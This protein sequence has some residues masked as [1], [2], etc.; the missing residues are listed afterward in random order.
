MSFL[1]CFF[2]SAD[3]DPQQALIEYSSADGCFVLQDLNSSHG[4]LVNNCRVHNAAVRL[5]AGDVVGFGFDGRLFK[6]LTDQP[7]Q[8]ICFS[9]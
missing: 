3:V 7:S 6:F 9:L 5:A 2:Q 4:T 1:F 8:V